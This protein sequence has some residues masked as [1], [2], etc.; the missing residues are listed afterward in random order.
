MITKQQ[1]CHIFMFWGCLLGVDVPIGLAMLY[2]FFIHQWHFQKEPLFPSL[3]YGLFVVVMVIVLVG[4]YYAQ[5][6]YN[7]NSSREKHIDMFL[8]AIGF[9]T[10]ILMGLIIMETGGVLRSI[11]SFYLIYLPSIVAIA[12][13]KTRYGLITVS[14]T[15]A[16]MIFIGLR[17]EVM[18]TAYMDFYGCTIFKIGYWLIAIIQL[19]AIVSVEGR[20][21]TA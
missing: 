7:L 12:F 13:T 21:K 5:L 1:Q 9:V 6:W 11:F 8:Y 15:S 18:P 17:W 3:V 2:D 14:I 4:P 19:I 16:V 20:A 10:C